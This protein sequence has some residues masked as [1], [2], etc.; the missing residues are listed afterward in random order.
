LP[1]SVSYVAELELNTYALSNHCQ[2]IT[3]G[4]DRNS[5]G[6]ALS[7]GLAD[8][9]IRIGG[10]PYIPEVPYRI[11]KEK[12]I[13]WDQQTTQYILL[14]PDQGKKIT[15]AFLLSKESETNLKLKY[16]ALF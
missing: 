9:K 1:I 7:I 3:H 6:T 8:Y 11:H 5:Y 14:W 15:K 4:T 13:E 16:A 12:N 2:Y 10:I